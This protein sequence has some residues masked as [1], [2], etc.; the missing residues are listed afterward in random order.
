MDTIMGQFHP[1]PIITTHLH[2][3]YL[4]SSIHPL[5]DLQNRCLVFPQQLS[6]SIPFLSYRN[7]ILRL[8]Y[9]LYLLSFV[10]SSG[11]LP[12]SSLAPE[13]LFIRHLQS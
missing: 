12:T 10:I 1:L 6:L 7:P 11:N 5:L 8:H 13:G 3:S 9:P 2:N 4:I